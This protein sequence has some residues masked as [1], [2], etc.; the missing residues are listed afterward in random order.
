MLSGL[1]TNR[2]EENERLGKAMLK[3]KKAR[4]RFNR[5]S[6]ACDGCRASRQ[7]P[8]KMREGRK[9]HTRVA[10]L[11]LRPPSPSFAPSLLPQR[12]PPPI[13]SAEYHLGPQLL[14]DSLRHLP[15]PLRL[16]FRH[17][18]AGC[19]RSGLSPFCHVVEPH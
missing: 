14:L 15:R 18:H 5:L 19:S 9:N 1:F 17:V 8:K 13:A 16:P 3:E 12:R 10:A 2:C 7:C 4:E 11:A 6:P